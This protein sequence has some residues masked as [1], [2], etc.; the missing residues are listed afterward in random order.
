MSLLVL[1]PT[2]G[3]PPSAVA[4]LQSFKE[5]AVLADS[6]ILFIVDEDDVQLDS[7]L[8][9]LPAEN[10]EVNEAIGSMGSALQSSATLHAAINVYRFIGFMG[11]DHRP[12]TKGWDQI[13]TQTLDQHG[14][15]FAY[16]NDLY[17]GQN[18]PTQVV[19]NTSIVNA[20]GWMAPPE[21]RH[22]YFDDSWK[23]LGESVGRLFFFPSVIIEHMHVY[24]GK[25]PMDEGYERVNSR[26]MNDHDRA[27][28]EVWRQKDAPSD[29]AKVRTALGL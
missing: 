3:R 9:S 19:M 4:L 22:L 12:R 11:D 29:I 10:V 6:A 5:T 1:C 14:G 15:G 18:L 13:L 17:Q 23:F 25:A 21:L 16:G 28:Y 26:E 27:V 2:R 24:A 8:E 20:L 7:Y